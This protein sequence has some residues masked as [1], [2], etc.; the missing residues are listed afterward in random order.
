MVKGW[1]YEIVNKPLGIVSHEISDEEEVGDTGRRY[2]AYQEG[3]THRHLLYIH[4]IF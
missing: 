1:M 4:T 2:I 3:M